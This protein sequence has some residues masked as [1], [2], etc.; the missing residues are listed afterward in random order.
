MTNKFSCD[1]C[2]FDGVSSVGLKIHTSRKHE[3]IPQ[4]DGESFEV[5]NTD[6]WWVNGYRRWLKSLENYKNVLLD[7]DEAPLSQEEKCSERDKITQ[8]RKE[9][10]GSNY[11][12]CPPWNTN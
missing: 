9:E 8:I 7:I 10:L 1:I 4:V 2:E 6:C 3:N 12:Y 11:I 5:R